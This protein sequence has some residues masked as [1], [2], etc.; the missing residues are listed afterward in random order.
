[1]S[2]AI[3][4]PWPAVAVF[5][6]VA[7]GLAWLV[8]LPLWL[9]DGAASPF[10]GLVAT[11]M[12]S[13]P[14]A[15]TLVVVL[16]MRSPRR[17]RLRSLGVWP[18][19]PV[20]RTIGFVV[21]AVLVPPALVVATALVSGALGLVELDLVSFSGFAAT[22]EAAGVDA[23]LVPLPVLVAAQ[24]AAIPL[25]ALVNSVFAFGE[26]IGWRGWLL[27]ALRPLGIWPA[28]IAS[29]ALWGAWHAPLILLGYNFGRTDVSGVLLMIG[30]CI[31]WG[32]LF[33]WARLRTGSVWPAVVGHGALN[34]AAGVVLVL[35][36]AGA[37]VDLAL[38]GPLGVVSWGILAVVAAILALAGQFRRDVLAQ[39]DGAA[40]VR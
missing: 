31:A 5:A 17:D 18:L 32:V 20:G 12:M 33:G 3:R 28:L 25:G 13:T 26:E 40:Q 15:A 9:G 19:R 16:A 11:G 4:V 24:L 37:D 1:M 2:A 29:G 39:G 21:A 34:A 8:A 23:A 6:V 7:V 14:L 10:L 22:I 27:P 35:S 38:V 30:G 36:A